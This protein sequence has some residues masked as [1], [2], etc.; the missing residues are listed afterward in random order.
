MSFGQVYW[1]NNRYV[2]ILEEVVDGDEDVAEKK[3]Q[4]E[5]RDHDALWVKDDQC[6]GQGS[7]ILPIIRTTSRLFLALSFTTLSST[8]M[9]GGVTLMVLE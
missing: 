7:A 8:S 2:C 6:E 4:G 1:L 9:G 5:Q 3:Y